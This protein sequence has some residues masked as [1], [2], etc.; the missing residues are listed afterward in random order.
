MKHATAIIIAT[1]IS[2]VVL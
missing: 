2:S 1:T